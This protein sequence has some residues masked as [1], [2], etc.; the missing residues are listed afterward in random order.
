MFDSL[1]R[2]AARAPRTAIGVW[3]VLTVACLALAVVGVG[4]ETLFE[5]LSTG[6]P[7]VPGSESTRA[8]EIIAENATGGPSLSL[9][10]EGVPVG[11]EG[12]TEPLEQARE[13][14]MAI[15]G[16]ALVIDP[17]ALPEGPQSPAAAPLVADG[18]DGFLVVVELEEDLE[19][20]AQDAALDEV[21]DVLR[22]VPA[23]LEPVAPDASGQVGGVSLIVE[24]I[25]DQVE[26]DLRT[27]E[28]VA[29]PVAL[30]VMVLVF[31]GFLAAS[32]PLAGA[33]A[34]IGAGLGAVYALTNV[35]DLDSSVVNVVTLLG[36]GLS[37]DYGL[38][39]VS[40]YREELHVLL[41]G[42][43][44]APHRRR[45]HDPVVETAL[46][47]TL[48]T[49]GR[50]VAF[51]AVTVAIS[52]SG[53]V[54]FRPEILRGFGASGVA[55]VLV[56]VA[57]ALTLVPAL[58]RLTGR[59]LVAPG[60]LARVPVLRWVL[61]RTGDVSS[62]EGVFSRLAAWVQRRPWL[63]LGGSVAVLALLAVPV[64]HMELR[65][66]AIELLPADSDQR[67]YVETIAAEYPASE[68]PAVRVVAR[69]TMEEVADWSA[70]VAALDDVVAVDPPAPLGEYVVLGVR[71][72]TQDA[73]GA[74]A[75][76]VVLALRDLP[77]PF[78]T[79]V[80]GQAAN[81]IDFVDALVDRAPL[82]VGIV[83]LAT[84]VLL[85]LMT[86]SVVIPLKA[87]LTNA[88]SLAASLGVLVWGFQD[89]HLEGLLQF[90]STGGIE[91][92]VVALIIAFGFGLAMDY[93]VFLLSRIKE[94]YD[95][96]ASN[97]DAVRLGLQRS[98]RI[99]TSAA[100]IIIVVFAGFI[101]GELL[102]IKEVGFALA[103]AVLID[104][105]L[106]RMLL[107][108]ATMTLL[109]RYNWWAPPFLRRIHDR[110]AITH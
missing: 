71:P 18:G 95:G 26:E 91:T 96:G 66:S 51:S 6:A 24:E 67:T 7:A 5:R 29:L 105:S 102:V 32:M 109:G 43:T 45:R 22:G 64:A 36:L 108:P 76:D 80:T 65:N 82:A 79:W 42:D 70:D 17:F 8:D 1:G 74:V 10:V 52:I 33:V 28:A 97:D 46:R 68:A 69:G 61:A 54:V 53:L 47:R 20:G 55:V 73:G 39:I 30:L 78:P 60:L 59:R 110:F 87:L 27:G 21:A 2:L 94:L 83:V 25:T 31:G 62:E 3:L 85:F 44:D 9:A 34:S 84:F 92:Y 15:D 40:R 100:V 38:L 14:L 89:G 23:L 16:V 49:A 104:A 77:A 93:E 88:V 72:D 50:T 11:T 99:I 101:V 37:I 35:L 13:D 103:V 75:R 4:G 19:D 57:T 107:V 56:A 98:G 41:D 58:L 106:V 63:V 86:G 81:Q 12:V 90:T 48:A